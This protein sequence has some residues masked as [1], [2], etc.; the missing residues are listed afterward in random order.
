MKAEGFERTLDVR[1]NQLYN[2]LTTV[3]GIPLQSCFSEVD[4]PIVLTIHISVPQMAPAISNPLTT[5]L[6]EL[7]VWL[8]GDES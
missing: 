6:A 2:L 5:P 7:N 3:P 1:T 4:F 8:L